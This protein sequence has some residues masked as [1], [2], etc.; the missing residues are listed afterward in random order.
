MTH[1]NIRKVSLVEYRRKGFRPQQLLTSLC[2]S[3]RYPKQEVIA[4][5]HER[6]EMELGYDE[7]KTELLEREETLRSKSPAAVNQELWGIL[8]AYNLIR[9]PKLIGQPA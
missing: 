6:W 1:V 3:S 5:Y 4:M 9:I 7:I 2:D 8:I